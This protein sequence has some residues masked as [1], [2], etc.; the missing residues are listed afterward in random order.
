MRVMMIAHAFP[1]TVGGVE[2]H[3][4][5]VTRL[6]SRRG[7]HVM[8]LVGGDEDPERTD[9][10][11]NVQVV[12]RHALRVSD[13]LRARTGFYREDRSI[14]LLRSLGQI[15][16]EQIG[17]FE[18]D[19]VHLH[20]GHHFAPELAEAVLEAAEVPVL[21]SVHDRVGEH[22]FDDTMLLGWAYTLFA[23]QYLRG[24]LPAAEPASVL[25]LGIDLRLFEPNGP[26]HPAF[27]G[28]ERPVVFHPARLLLWKGVET[29][30]D[31]FVQL[32]RQRGAGTLVLCSSEN[33]VDDPGEV[34]ALRTTLV[35]RAAAAGAAEHVR[36]LEFDRREMPAALRSCDIVWY[37]TLDEE[38]LGLVPLEAMACGVPIVVTASGGMRETVVDRVTGRVVPRG[39]AVALADATV[40]LLDDPRAASSL[41]AAA[42]R[43]VTRYGLDEYVDRLEAVYAAA[44]DQAAVR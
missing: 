9:S 43:A 3:L 5:D 31:A 11:R 19:V 42:T 7:H 1:P 15:V 29:S 44:L 23:S 37:P 10:V 21:N 4:W 17:E 27:A 26:S 39:D 36:F 2:T 24:A 41:V 8:C 18:P 16:H 13:L 20:N 38:P 6:L 40:A 32:R 30:V 25:P 34:A 35:T 12:R 22:M 28:F 33:I 14:D